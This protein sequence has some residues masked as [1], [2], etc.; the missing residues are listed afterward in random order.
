MFPVISSYAGYVKE[1]V[2]VLIR[3]LH[4]VRLEAIFGGLLM[5]EPHLTPPS[6]CV[7]AGAG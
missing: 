1:R 5:R 2:H 4:L 6:I 7:K 3:R